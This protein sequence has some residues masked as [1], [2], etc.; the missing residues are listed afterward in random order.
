MANLKEDSRIHQLH[1]KDYFVYYYSYYLMKLT[2]EKDLYI[3]SKKKMYPDHEMRTKE[4]LIW[5]YQLS[6]IV[7]VGIQLIEEFA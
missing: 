3:F 2:Y 4:K 5:L 6:N 7:N 1:R